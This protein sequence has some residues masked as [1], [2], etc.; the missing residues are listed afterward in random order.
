VKHHALG[1]ARLP[2]LDVSERRADED[3]AHAGTCHHGRLRAALP[4]QG[5]RGAV[6]EGDE[7]DVVGGGHAPLVEVVLERAALGVREVGK[8]LAAFLALQPFH[9]AGTGGVDRPRIPTGEPGGRAGGRFDQPV[10]RF[11]DS[12]D[13]SGGHAGTRGSGFGW[14]GRVSPVSRREIR[15][16]RKLG[17]LTGFEPAASRATTWRSIQA[18]LQPPPSRTG[19]PEGTRTPDPQLRRLPLYP[20][21]L[22]A[23]ER[24][25]AARGDPDAV[26]VRDRHPPPRSSPPEPTDTIAPSRHLSRAGE[27]RPRA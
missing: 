21:E 24:L 27:G 5:L 17:W 20:T 16:S 1:D 25:Q 7:R 13:L 2:E 18:E 14:P 12:P 15:D 26:A 23:P 3:A 9:C 19:A 8:D 22:Q 4:T 10:A 6:H 11:A